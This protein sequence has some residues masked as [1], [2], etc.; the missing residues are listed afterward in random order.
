MEM[1]GAPGRCGA[2]AAT[3]G[4]APAAA[5]AAAAAEALPLA[6]HPAGISMP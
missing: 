3:G 4:R 2:A 1:E 6:V 5:V